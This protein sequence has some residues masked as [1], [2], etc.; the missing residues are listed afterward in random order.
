MNSSGEPCHFH[1]IQAV[2]AIFS[3][4][5]LDWCEMGKV[6]WNHW[7]LQLKSYYSKLQQHIFP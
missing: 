4:V 1:S 6:N 5:N 7:T 2:K 3:H